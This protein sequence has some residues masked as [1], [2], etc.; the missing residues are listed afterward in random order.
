MSMAES[1][2]N[3]EQSLQ[4]ILVSG[5]FS[6]P[7][8]R[9]KLAYLE[10]LD[11]VL[12][13]QHY[14]LF[15][16]NLTPQHLST[17]CAHCSLPHFVHYNHLLKRF[18]RIDPESLDDAYGEAIALESEETGVSPGQAARK[19][20]QFL[21]LMDRIIRRQRPVL[22]ILWHQFNSLHYALATYSER[23]AL[24]VLYAE[25][26]LL[27]GTVAFDAAGQMAESWV[28]TDNARFLALEL[29]QE[30]QSAVRDYL[31][32][33]RRERRSRK[34]QSGKAEI[35]GKLRSIQ[36]QGRSIVF[37]AGE[38]LYRSGILPT[39][40][41]RARLHSPHFRDTAE[42]L[43]ALCAEAKERAWHV[44]FKPHPQS[45]P[46]T[47]PAVSEDILTVAEGA[48]VFDCILHSDVTATLVS[49]VSYLALIQGKPCVLMGRNP[50][51]GKGC[52][53][54]VASA[55]TLGSTVEAA[56]SEG[57]TSA[58]RDAWLRH[59]AQLCVHY[60]Y[61]LEPDVE[62]A[63]GRGVRDAAEYIIEHTRPESA[64]P[65]E[66]PPRTVA[67]NAG[68][69]F[70]M[71]HAILRFSAPLARTVAGLLPTQ[72]KRRLES[73][74]EAEESNSRPSGRKR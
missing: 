74:E 58:Q 30:Q 26:G 61:A 45:R 22:A 66:I 36:E 8:A 50:L 37:Y 70:Q 51:S 65:L 15:L 10:R 46:W 33:I 73:S 29:T 34:P 43:G 3:S 47:H 23:I 7:G 62:E 71:L 63:I 64:G 5:Y 27:P 13:R 60:L 12:R 31:D 4:T 56:V 42:A 40:S 49:Q 68:A 16:V 35:A 24:P 20:L 69:S 59:A 53:Y 19:L 67:A 25:Y 9:Q 54:E 18:G 44:V 11:Y 17:P 52:V 32:R 41:P 48:N 2:S 6:G 57:F 28:T 72:A 55:D 1:K 14:R 21:D 39:T 38:N